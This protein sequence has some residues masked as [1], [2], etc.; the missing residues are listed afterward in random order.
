M[1]HN[2]FIK[3][4]CELV[5]AFGNSVVLS[6]QNF[7]KRHHG[8]DGWTHTTSEHIDMHAYDDDSV[9]RSL[10]G[11][12]AIVLMW[13]LRVLSARNITLFQMGRNVKTYTLTKRI[14]MWRDVT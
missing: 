11:P 8:N 4:M 14:R 9:T 6:D 12:S 1:P 5:A 13:C 3:H 2:A 10:L 7:K